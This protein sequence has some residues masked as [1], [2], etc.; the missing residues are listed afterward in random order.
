MIQMLLSNRFTVGELAEACG[1][2]SAAASGHLRIMKDRGFLDHEKEGR[3]VYYRI[4]QPQLR[5][6]FGCVESR[7]G[8]SASTGAAPVSQSEQTPE[9]SD[10]R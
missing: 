1:I 6:I 3:T 7:F 5:S 2:P 8:C 10:D 4:V 9:A